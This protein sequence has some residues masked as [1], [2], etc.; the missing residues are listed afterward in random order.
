MEKVSPPSSQQ[1]TPLTSHNNKN[2]MTEI[3]STHTMK[4]KSLKELGNEEKSAVTGEVP[5]RANFK[6]SNTCGSFFANCQCREHQ[7]SSIAVPFIATETVCDSKSSVTT[8]TIRTV[9]KI[10]KNLSFTHPDTPVIFTEENRYPDLSARRPSREIF[11]DD[12]NQKIEIKHSKRA[13]SPNLRTTNYDVCIHPEF[14]IQVVPK[15]PTLHDLNSTPTH[16]RKPLLKKN[17]KSFPS[18]SSSTATRSSSFRSF[19]S[20]G[21]FSSYS[22]DEENEESE[23]SEKV[24]ELLTTDL[25][26]SSTSFSSSQSST[27]TVEHQKQQS[28]QSPTNNTAE[29][30]FQVI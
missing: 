12:G 17:S 19:D 2:N 28:R 4:L 25:D 20:D 8:K 16:H 10:R 22:V 11:L 23:L 5:S 26:K 21:T 24:S 27:T 9:P 14:Q 15:S 29:K 6:R 30:F 13:S 3:S 1:L 18:V 7:K